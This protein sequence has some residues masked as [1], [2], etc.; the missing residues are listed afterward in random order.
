MKILLE[1]TF[2][3]M[4]SVPS[5]ANILDCCLTGNFEKFENYKVDW[6]SPILDSCME[7]AIIGNSVEIVQTIFYRKLYLDCP[8]KYFVFALSL[9]RLGIIRRLAR[10]AKNAISME[11]KI[12]L[13]HYVIIHQNTVV[14]ELFLDWFSDSFLPEFLQLETIRAPERNIEAA[15]RLIFLGRAQRRGAVIQPEIVS[16]TPLLDSCLAKIRNG[17]D[18]PAS[19]PDNCCCVC[20]ENQAVIVLSCGHKN[21]CCSCSITLIE[22]RENCPI[23]R[24]KIIFATRVY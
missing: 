5:K 10:I 18:S 9:G 22:K 14:I 12:R 6:W 1:L 20:G 19:S 17:K 21:L 7:N 11:E 24:E 16:S 4:G 23:C 15:R 3:K 13:L 8:I 2:K